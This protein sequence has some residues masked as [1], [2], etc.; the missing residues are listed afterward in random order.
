[1]APGAG[2]DGVMNNSVRLTA[3]VV[4]SYQL[5]AT[6]PAAG[7]GAVPGTSALPA[8]AAAIGGSLSASGGR[9][10][11]GLGKE[12]REGPNSA[13]FSQ[14]GDR[15]AFSFASGRIVLFDPVN[16]ACVIRTIDSFMP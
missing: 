3:T 9:G 16:G 4:A 5:A 2:S 8:S 12:R 10:A 15:C 6:F 11:G 13:A 7:V 1:M 14:Q